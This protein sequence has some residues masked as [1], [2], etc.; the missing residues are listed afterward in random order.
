LLYVELDDDSAEV[1]R[2]VTIP[3]KAGLGWGQIPLSPKIFHEGGYTLRAYTNWMQNF[4]GDAF[5]TQ[6]FYLGI[7]SRNAWLANST[8]GISRVAGKNQLDVDI[9]LKS[10]QNQPVGLRNV[11]VKIYEGAYYLYKENMLTGVDGGLKL[12]KVLKDNVNGRL[13]RVQL[14]C[15][16][17]VDNGK[18]I[19]IPLDINRSQK[20]D[21]QFLPEGGNLVAGLQSTVGFK[22]IAEDGKGTTV[23]GTIYDSRGTKI[24]DFRSLFKGMGSFTFTPKAGEVYTAKLTGPDAAVKAYPL[25]AVKPAGTVMHLTNPPKGE[26]FT[27]SLAGMEKMTIDSA[28][29]VVGSSSGKICYLE[30]VDAR[31]TS[32]EIA[33]ALFPSGIARITLLKGKKPLNERAI[34]INHNDQ[35][36]IRLATNKTSYQKRDSVALEIEVKDAG[37]IPVQGSFSI[38]VT[39]NGQVRPD[40][41]GNYNIA[42]RLLLNGGLKG[43]VENPG[44]YLNHTDEQTWAALDNLMLTQGW[45]GF[46]WKDVFSNSTEPLK[47]KAEKEFQVSGRVINAFKK[48]VPNAP[49]LIS[50]QKPNF[51]VTTIADAKGNYTFSRLPTIDSGSFFLQA[52][53]SKGNKLSFGNISVNKFRAPEVP[54][55]YEVT[56]PW[57][58][59]AEPEQLNYVAKIAE[60]EKD[61]NVI[62]AGTLLRNV[63]INS[64]KLIKG[65]WYA[66][67]WRPPVVAFDEQDINESAVMNL[68]QLLRQKIPGFKV[69]NSGKFSD[70]TAK[71]V[72]DSLPSYSVTIL[73]DGPA[74]N[75]LPINID[76]PNSVQELKDELAQFPATLYKGLEMYV[77]DRL[78]TITIGLTSKNGAGYY[79]NIAPDVTTY[80]PLPLLYPQQFYSPKYKLNQPAVGVPDYR[81]TVYWEPDV[82]TDNNGKAKLS[83]FTTDLP[84]N[85]TINIQGMSNIGDIGSLVIKFPALS[86]SAK[87]G[88]D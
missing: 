9:K 87:T 8:S 46:D 31:Q 47:Y 5:F 18:T 34:F 50:S 82:T 12:S 52:R 11:E 4:G 69:V 30:P 2:R 1:V 38:A 24:I 45:T 37:G 16:D 70:G 21:L 76:E 23:T 25:P 32:L 20:T 65:S 57:Y 60:L 44:Y 42:T 72:I 10:G 61:D 48:P 39:D 63:K 49:V 64:R 66:K 67:S 53:N 75:F 79:K 86:K 26:T 19:Q 40:T 77:D 7:P 83:F 35:L 55:L 54:R 68:Y 88:S 62:S 71:Y 85:Y 14:K 59:N 58:V 73:V 41:A 13:L 84:A 3:V 36:T 56:M 22:A 6:R 33:K 80:R 43:T 17:V 29:Y 27:V 81:S 74:P 51:I 15:L 28:C 78:E